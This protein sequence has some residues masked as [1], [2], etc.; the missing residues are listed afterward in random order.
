MKK[1]KRLKK[2]HAREKRLKFYGISS[3]CIALLM[4]FTLLSSITLNG[5]TAMQQAYIPLKIMVS[6]EK[7][8][9]SDGEVDAQKALLFNWD[10]KVKRHSVRI[11]P[12]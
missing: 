9:N 4:L 11:S 1:D 2:R 5:Y 3:I 12:K 7:L 8:L 6:S 10:S